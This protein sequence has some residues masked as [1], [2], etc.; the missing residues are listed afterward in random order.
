MTTNP[1]E[2]MPHYCAETIKEAKEL[3]VTME[4]LAEINAKIQEIVPMELYIE[5]DYSTEEGKAVLQRINT[6]KKQYFPEEQVKKTVNPP[7]MD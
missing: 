3:G 4:T 5:N 1:T 2:T 7:M 6:I